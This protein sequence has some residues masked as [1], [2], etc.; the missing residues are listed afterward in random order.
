MLP[1]YY[2]TPELQACKLSTMWYTES[3][4]L[5]SQTAQVAKLQ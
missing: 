1:A 2:E 5:S 3:N 4:F